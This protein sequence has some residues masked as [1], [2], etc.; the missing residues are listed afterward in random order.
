[1]IE[2]NLMIFLAF[3]YLG[4]YGDMQLTHGFSE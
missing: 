2:Y 3:N 1:M 4:I